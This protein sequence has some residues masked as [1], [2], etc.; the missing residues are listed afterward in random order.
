MQRCVSLRRVATL[1]GL[2]LVG[3]VLPARAQRPAPLDPE[4]IRV[5]ADPDN[6]PSSNDKLEGYENKLATLISQELKAK[7]EYVWYPTRRGYFRILNGMYCDL[8]MEVPAGLDMAGATKAYFRSGY[9][10]V[11]RKGS[12]L[13]DINS[14]AD[15]RLKKVK[16]GVNIYTSDAENSPPAMAL[17]HYGVVGNLVGF[18]TFFDENNRPEDIVN[19]V[20]KKDVDLAIA[21]GPLAGFYAKSAT[22]P[23]VLTVLPAKDSLS[24]FP[25]QYN[26]GIA[27]RRSDKEFKDSLNA[28]LTRRQSDVQAILKE[29]A[30][31]LLPIEQGHGG[32]KGEA[33][34]SS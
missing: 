15:P 18:S 10:F 20:A 2:G 34:A 22:V 27:V 17:S 26:I 5:C 30:V 32:E 11:T 3:F 13:D 19:A 8:A 21:W 25:F 23:L 6:M 7:L 4:K 16:I 9:V 33:K 12:G 29:Y 1:A 24:D 14:L 31:P 28:V